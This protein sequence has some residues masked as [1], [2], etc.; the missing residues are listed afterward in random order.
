MYGCRGGPGGAKGREM[1]T[2]VD[3][4][5]SI[6][7]PYSF[8]QNPKNVYVV[9]GARASE[10]KVHTFVVVVHTAQESICWTTHGCRTME[11]LVM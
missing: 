9:P 3:G 5:E 2:A 1:V 10:P 7:G 8:E 4:A 6:P 11:Q